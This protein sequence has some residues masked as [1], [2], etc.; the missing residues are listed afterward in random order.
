MAP[1]RRRRRV[2]CCCMA[3][4][5][6]SAQESW[7]AIGCGWRAGGSRGRRGRAGGWTGTGCS[8]KS[9]GRQGYGGME[10]AETPRVCQSAR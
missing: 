2:P 10:D 8:A 1:G 9:A 7:V 5:Y 4:R 3:G 6:G